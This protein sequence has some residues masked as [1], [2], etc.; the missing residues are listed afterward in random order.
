MT[1]W[2]IDGIPPRLLANAREG[3]KSWPDVYGCVGLLGVTEC[4]VIKSEFDPNERSP[5]PDQPSRKPWVAPTLVKLKAG[6][7]ENGFTT[8][9]NDGQ[10]TQS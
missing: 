3:I 4:E 6:S 7:A 1:G 5:Q 2:S 10:F 8:N 9:N